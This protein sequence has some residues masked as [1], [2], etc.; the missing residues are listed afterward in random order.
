MSVT[1]FT[2][3]TRVVEVGKEALLGTLRDEDGAMSG[4]VVEVLWF[5]GLNQYLQPGQ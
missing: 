2:A 1:H 3:P 5:Q 4:D